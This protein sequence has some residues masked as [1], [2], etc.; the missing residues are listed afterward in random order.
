MCDNTSSLN[1]VPIPV[2][3]RQ[4]RRRWRPAPWTA[5]A[6]QKT[7]AFWTEQRPQSK[8]Q[9]LRPISQ[10]WNTS[11]TCHQPWNQGSSILAQRK[12]GVSQLVVLP[13]ADLKKDWASGTSLTPPMPPYL[14]TDDRGLYPTWRA[15]PR[16]QEQPETASTSSWS[17]T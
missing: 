12:W 3:G 11:P 10:H 4:A 8:E 7:P 5:L 2:N 9:Q 15:R 14:P 6:C 13:F 1:A 16:S 17:K